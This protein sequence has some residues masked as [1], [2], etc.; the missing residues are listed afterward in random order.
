ME[1]VPSTET[2]KEVEDNVS[3]VSKEVSDMSLISSEQPRHL[4]FNQTEADTKFTALSEGK[5]ND[6]LHQRG[7]RAFELATETVAAVPSSPT[8]AQSAPAPTTPKTP[9]PI[10]AI[11]AV[12]MDPHVLLTSAQSGPVKRRLLNSPFK[13]SLDRSPGRKYL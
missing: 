13:P 2:D 12:T 5:Q 6:L 4:L 11:A 3:V 7:P 8:A 10:P 9:R 1:A